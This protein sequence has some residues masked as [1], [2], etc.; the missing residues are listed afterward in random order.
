MG[1][2]ELPI[3]DLAKGG[4]PVGLGIA[5]TVIKADQPNAYGIALVKMHPQDTVGY[6]RLCSAD[7]LDTADTNLEP[8]EEG[9]DAEVGAIED[10]IAWACRVYNATA[11]PYGPLRTAEPPCFDVDPADSR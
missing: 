11:A 7:P 8:Y 10:R 4:P 2:Q 5:V 3:V 6:V 1:S 9:V